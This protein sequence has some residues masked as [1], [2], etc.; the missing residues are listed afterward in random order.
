MFLGLPTESYL[1]LRSAGVKLIPVSAGY[2]YET[3]RNCPVLTKIR[4][5]KYLRFA[6]CDTC[7]QLRSRIVFGGYGSR[8]QSL[9]EY[10][11]EKLQRQKDYS[12]HLAEIK[13]ERGAY[14]VRRREAVMF[15]ENTMSMIIDGSDQMNNGVPW[16]HQKTHAMQGGWKLGV[17]VYGVIVHGIQNFIFLLPDHVK[18]GKSA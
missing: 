4:C 9:L 14:W 11:R 5:R 13:S 1:K 15:P 2:F 8:E 7:V 17:H 3:W 6:K 16:Y 12:I 10:Q 18:Q